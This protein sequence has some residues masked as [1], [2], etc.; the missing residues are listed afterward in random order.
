MDEGQISLGVLQSKWQD[1]AASELAF[2]RAVFEGNHRPEYLEEMRQR[3]DPAAPFAGWMA[4]YV[5][6]TDI[7]VARILDIGAGPISCLGWVYQ[8]HRLD[9]TPVDALA[10]LYKELLAE[11]NIVPPRATQQCEAED[12]LRL[13]DE[14]SFDLVHSRNAVDHCYDAVRVIDNAVRLLK[15]GATFIIQSMIDEG[16]REAYAGLHQWNLSREGDDLIVW[17]PGFRRS[18][19]EHF[20]DRAT[21]TAQEAA[22][23]WI[24][25]FIKR[26]K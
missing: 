19:R 26:L 16:V 13:F 6:T 17:R 15:P 4:E 1:G 11:L 2:W 22:G 25:A 10:T 3:A 5:Q 8:G 12:L 14:A 21:V 9:I 23:N 20:G 24:L 7:A 18:V